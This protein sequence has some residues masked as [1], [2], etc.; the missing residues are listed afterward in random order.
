MLS[1]MYGKTR[2]NNIRND[3]I[4]E[5]VRVAPISRKDGGK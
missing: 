1:W 3:N 4:K 2:R 5:N